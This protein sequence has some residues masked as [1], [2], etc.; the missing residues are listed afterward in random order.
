VVFNVHLQS[1]GERKPWR[2]PGASVLDPTFWISYLLQYRLAFE[3]RAWETRQLRALMD[4]ETVPVLLCGDFN[5]TPHSR[6]YRHLAAGRQD[7]FREAGTGWGMSYHRRLPL[8]RIDY[9][10]ASEEW[11]PV[12]ART[13]PAGLSDHLPVLVRLRWRD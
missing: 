13:V 11:E 9:V 8:V 5:S 7:A 3:A 12:S 1:F 10:L 6:V 4:R 2:D